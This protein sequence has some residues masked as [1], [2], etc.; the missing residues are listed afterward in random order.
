MP[1]LLTT[2]PSAFVP[3]DDDD[4]SNISDGLEDVMPAKKQQ[5]PKSKTPVKKPIKP[6]ELA[7]ES[8]DEDAAEGDQDNQDDQ[9][10][11]EE[12]EEEF[13]VEKIISHAFDKHVSQSRLSTVTNLLLTSHCRALS[14]MR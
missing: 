11:S 8:D 13:Q 3:D 5:K 10:D 2:S 7:N 1:Q 9:D 12:E 14:N 6:A 4:D